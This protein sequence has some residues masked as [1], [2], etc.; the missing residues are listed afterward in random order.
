[1]S[2]FADGPIKFN[3]TLDGKLNIQNMSRFGRDFSIV[4]IPYALKLLMQELQTMNIQMRIITEDNIDQLMNLSYSD[5]INKLLKTGGTKELSGL[6][7]KYKNVIAQQLQEKSV[8]SRAPVP[9]SSSDSS[10]IPYADASPAYQPSDDGEEDNESDKYNPNSEPEAQNF[11]PHS[12]EEPPPVSG[13]KIKNEEL[14]TEFEALGERD[15]VLLMKMMAEKKAKAGKEAVEAQENVVIQKPQ[16]GGGSNGGGAS[17]GEG[18]NEA[19][20]SILKVEEEKPESETTMEETNG[21]SGSETKAI[22][23]DIRPEIASSSGEVKQI[24]L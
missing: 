2:P 16:I 1:L 9:E 20:T 23:F 18:G 6:Y 5:N 4:R 19:V 17:N 8:R 21:D 15:K 10:S 13:I 14:K 11:E 7:G 12:P 22:S 3:T 24:T